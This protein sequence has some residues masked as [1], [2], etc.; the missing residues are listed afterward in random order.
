MHIHMQHFLTDL[1]QQ[2]SLQRLQS[3]YWQTFDFTVEKRELKKNKQT[4][5]CM[6]DTTTNSRMGNKK[7]CA[8]DPW[9]SHQQKPG[10]N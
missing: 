4:H 7:P 6:T 8:S 9:E 3:S 10:H 5:A 2:K 1:M